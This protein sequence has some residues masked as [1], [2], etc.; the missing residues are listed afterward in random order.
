MVKSRYIPRIYNSP[1]WNHDRGGGFLAQNCL[2]EDDAVNDIIPW[3]IG[4][5][6]I[7]A[8]IL[9]TWQ[10]FR[11]RAAQRKNSPAVHGVTQADGTVAG[12]RRAERR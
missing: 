11:T 7:A 9:G 10:Y 6:L 12:E 3:L 4:F 1:A 5:T 8:L 2:N